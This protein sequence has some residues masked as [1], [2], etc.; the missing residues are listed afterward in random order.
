MSDARTR[1]LDAVAGTALAPGIER[2]ARG[3]HFSYEEEPS[4]L[5]ASIMA[6][7]FALPFH[8]KKRRVLG[9][10]TGGAV[11]GPGSPRRSALRVSART[12]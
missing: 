8:R 2:A 5:F 1:M 4:L 6:A 9:A 10:L 7:F 11:K 3:E 12:V